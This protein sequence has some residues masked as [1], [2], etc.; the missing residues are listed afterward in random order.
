MENKVEYRGFTIEQDYRNPYSNECEYM[1]YPTNEGIQHDADQDGD[2]MV[3]CGNCKWAY[4]IDEAK[5]EIDSYKEIIDESD[6]INNLKE[7]YTE[8]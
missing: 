1:F 5:D 3:Y 6:E 8:R 7:P 2:D 4:S